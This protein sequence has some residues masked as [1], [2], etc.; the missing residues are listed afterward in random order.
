[1][2]SYQTQSAVS[3]KGHCRVASDKSISHRSLIFSSLAEGESRI[4]NLLMGE[5][6][7]RTL[8]I[9]RQLGVKTSHSAEDLTSNDE[10]VVQGQ[11]LNSWKAPTDI[12]YCGNSG[13]TMRLML[14]A[15]CGQGFAS[16]LTGDA[17][18]N[19]RPMERVFDPLKQMGGQFRVEQGEQRLIHVE[20]RH[21]LKGFHYQSPVASA[22]VKTSLL[23][24]GLSAAG[25]TQIT[26]PA[27]SR[28]H[29][30]LMLQGMGADIQVQDKTVTLN[31][32]KPL[33]PIQMDVPADISSAAFF[34]VAA[35]L[36]AGSQ[37]ILKNVSLNPTRVGVLEILQAMGADIHPQGMRLSAGELAGDLGVQSS[38]LKNVVI[39]GDVIPRLIDEIPILALAGACSQGEMRVRDAK[40]L[41]VK[42][43]DRITAIVT[44]LRKFGVEIE[45]YEDGFRLQGLGD[46]SKLQA[47]QSVF[48]SYG[49]HRMA[50]MGVIAGLLCQ[51]P[52]KIDDVECAKTSFPEFFGL[53]ED[54]TQ[55]Q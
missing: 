47:P 36:V 54:L 9:L 15:L 42:E 39:Q 50:M 51:K 29:S 7:L 40:E 18:L 52:F 48:C 37:V 20:S 53:L 38:P 2:A 24:A 12:L 5:D 11:G 23:L 21:S 27:V 6:V 28:N 33:Q 30:E 41:R 4:R 44:E 55:V 43:T 22:Q 16:T 31:P 19:K 34:L 45:E 32:G 17:S 46:P 10:L 35:S 14:G 13:T 1:M 8:T 3:L 26:E 49:D 25:A